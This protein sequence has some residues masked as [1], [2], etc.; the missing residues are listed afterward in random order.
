MIA[1]QITMSNARASGSLNWNGSTYVFEDAP[2][3]GE[4]N[5]GKLLL[6]Y[7]ARL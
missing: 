4:K 5:W 2:F 1:G 3:Y 7:A 6:Q